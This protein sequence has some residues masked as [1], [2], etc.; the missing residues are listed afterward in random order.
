MKYVFN[1]KM[2]QYLVAVGTSLS[3]SLT[4][5][6]EVCSMAVTNSS[7]SRTQKGSALNQLQHCGAML[8]TILL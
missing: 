2:A 5:I 6:E 1:T 7:V 3:S 8:H 4:T